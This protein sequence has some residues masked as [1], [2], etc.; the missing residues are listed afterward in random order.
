MIMIIIM[1]IIIIIINVFWS[2]DAYLSAKLR[3][4]HTFTYS[5]F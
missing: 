1:I 2:N 4:P 5:D 3:Q